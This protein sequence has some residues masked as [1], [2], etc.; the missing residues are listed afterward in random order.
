MNNH[1]QVIDY[2]RLKRISPEKIDGGGG[3][4]EYNKITQVCILF[5]FIG[6]SF[7]IKRFKDKQARQQSDIQGTLRKKDKHL[8]S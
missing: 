7:L 1:P 4:S 3:G 8:F 5:I 2:S 6:F